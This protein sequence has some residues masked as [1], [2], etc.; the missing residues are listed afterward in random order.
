MNKTKINTILTIYLIATQLQSLVIATPKNSLKSKLEIYKQHSR[1][2]STDTT[3]STGQL[4][5]GNT[6]VYAF[7]GEDITSLFIPSTMS[8]SN[9]TTVASNAAE[10]QQMGIVPAGFE[11]TL[12]ST[13]QLVN[14]VNLYKDGTLSLSA[15]VEQGVRVLAWGMTLSQTIIDGDFM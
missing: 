12:Q 5:T 1:V 9:L 11:E 13:M 6:L 8:S 3:S 10:V 4:V 14:V 7:F 15:V 2:L